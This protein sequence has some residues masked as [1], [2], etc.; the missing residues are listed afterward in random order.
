MKGTHITIFIC[1]AEV[2]ILLDLIITAV[3]FGETSKISQINLLF[4]RFVSV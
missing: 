3:L 1:F 2:F 4:R